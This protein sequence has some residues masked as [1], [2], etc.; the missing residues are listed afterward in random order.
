MQKSLLRVGK[1][2]GS[3]GSS[4]VGE[5]R[6]IGTRVI[7]AEFPDSR[8]AYARFELDAPN[9][10]VLPLLSLS[11]TCACAEEGV[12]EEAKAA[13]GEARA[14][15]RFADV[16]FADAGFANDTTKSTRDG[17]WPP[18]DRLALHCGAPRAGWQKQLK[19]MKQRWEP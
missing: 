11:P 19:E 16:G 6:G 17:S 1:V 13:G 10:V 14:G 5:R 7:G 12:G 18:L 4:C 3:M 9:L 15:E 2:G 8:F